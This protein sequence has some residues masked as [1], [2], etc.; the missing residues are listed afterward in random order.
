MQIAVL[1]ANEAPTLILIEYSNFTD[2][3]SLKLALKLPKQIKINDYT[4]KL[5]DD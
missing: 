1:I 4:I 2:I 3:F 5:V